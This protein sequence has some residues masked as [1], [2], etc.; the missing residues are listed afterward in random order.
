MVDELIRIHLINEVIDVT[1][2]FVDVGNPT[3]IGL[4]IEV[5]E[6]CMDRWKIGLSES[7]GGK[8]PMNARFRFVEAVERQFANV[9]MI[10]FEAFNK[11]VML[12]NRLRMFLCVAFFD[13]FW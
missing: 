6:M 11:H 10:M 9:A 1:E 7:V 5:N 8:Q 3:Q 2:R 4:N 13:L 12:A